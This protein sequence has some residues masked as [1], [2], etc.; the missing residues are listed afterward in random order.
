MSD[1]PLWILNTNCLVITVGMITIMFAQEKR[2]RML[3]KMLEDLNILIEY[4]NKFNKETLVSID[5]LGNITDVEQGI[6]NGR[7]VQAG[8]YTL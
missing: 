2:F 6:K 1:W 5:S 4:T 7:K 8:K 3:V